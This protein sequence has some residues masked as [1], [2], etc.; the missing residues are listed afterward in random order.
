MGITKCERVY[1]KIFNNIIV[2]ETEIYHKSVWYY[3]SL[4][5]V[6]R[7]YK[8]KTRFK[9]RYKVPNSSEQYTGKSIM[10]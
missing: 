3:S 5:N 2:T 7:S 6:S 4:C 1:L 9:N 10:I 8:L